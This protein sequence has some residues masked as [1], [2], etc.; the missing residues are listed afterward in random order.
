[1]QFNMQIQF[2]EKIIGPLLENLMKSLIKI[3]IQIFLEE[4]KD[5]FVEPS[6]YEKIEPFQN[7][8]KN[9]ILNSGAVGTKKIVSRIMNSIKEPKWNANQDIQ[10]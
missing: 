9:K 1:M 3:N 6:L 7:R 5:T 10:L 2:Q 8:I 4:T